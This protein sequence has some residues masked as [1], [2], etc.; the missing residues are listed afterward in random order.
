MIDSTEDSATKVHVQCNK[1]EG[2][3]NVASCYRKKMLRD[4]TEYVVMSQEKNSAVEFIIMID[5]NQN[6]KSCEMQNFLIEN[7]LLGTNQHASKVAKG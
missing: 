1:I 7:E 4:L 2:K 6:I 3:C 5:F